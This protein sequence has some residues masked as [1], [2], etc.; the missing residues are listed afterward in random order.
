MTI[1]LLIKYPVLDQPEMRKKY[2]VLYE[3][4]DLRSG[5]IVLLSNFLFLYRRYLLGAVV[6]F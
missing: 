6:V 1:F 4:L 2:G 5:K 3:G